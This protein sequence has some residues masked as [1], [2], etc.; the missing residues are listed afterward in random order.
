MLAL[1]SPPK[2]HSLS[3][4]MISTPN[5]L[6][7]F[8]ADRLAFRSL[9]LKGESHDTVELVLGVERKVRVLS[10][11]RFGVGPRGVVVGQDLEGGEVHGLQPQAFFS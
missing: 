4:N 1:P 11:H 5:W 10:G 8:E 2:V 7:T 3:A 9:F 6:A